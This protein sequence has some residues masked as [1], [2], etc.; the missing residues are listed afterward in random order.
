MPPFAILAQFGNGNFMALNNL[1]VHRITRV[2]P[3]ELST[4]GLRKTS[5]EVD[6]RVDEFFRE[7]KQCALK[8]AG[9]DYG[10]FSDDSAAH[11]VSNWLREFVDEKLSF[12]SFSQ[13]FAQHLKRELDKTEAPLE[14]FLVIAYETLEGDEQL[15]AFIVQHNRG[16]YIDSDLDLSES[17]SL[18]TSGIRL[19]AKVSFSDWKSDEEHRQ[20]NAVTLLRWR[21]EKELSD[22]FENTI[23]FAE[24]ID[25]S[26][27]TEEFLAVVNDYTRSLPNEVAEQTRSQV[28]EYCLQQDSVGKPVVIEELSNQLQDTKPV[29]S[30][31]PYTPPPKFSS[32]VA[33]KK[34]Q[35]KPELIPDKKQIRNFVRIS[36]RNELV[37]MSFASSCLGDS[38]VYDPETDSLTIKNLP[39]A[40]KTRLKKHASD[41]ILGSD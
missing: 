28:V 8:R 12:D 31:K 20:G 32:Y 7:M 5:M 41:K 10:R 38:I 14:G 29:E 23:G 19:A 26:A 17:L 9:K 11:P 34:P 1:I 18:D 30:E 33:E 15:H 16:S 24:K 4:L 6:G 3:S 25:L 27:E 2:N 40:L 22:V 13:K 37:S 36:G 21:G 39:S 35:A